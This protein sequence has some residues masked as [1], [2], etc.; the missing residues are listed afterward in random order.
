MLAEI[1]G[2]LN[3]TRG[4]HSESDLDFE[5]AYRAFTALYRSNEL[6]VIA[7]IHPQGATVFQTD[8]SQFGSGRGFFNNFLDAIDGSYCNYSAFGENGDNPT[9]DPIYPT[10]RRQCGVFKPTN[11]ISISYGL[12]EADFPANYQQRQCN[13]FMKL[14]LQGV[15]VVVA[16]GDSGAATNKNTCQGPRGDVFVPNYLSCP[17]VTLVGSTTLPEGKNPGDPEM[18]TASFSSGGGFSN[19]YTRPSY[20][21]SN[22]QS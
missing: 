14:G 9:I 1:D 2:A 18:S 10:G 5:I 13:E 11:V 15:S 6:T 20:Q 12:T 22:V 21:D 16:S 19:I 8:E 3:Y 17:Y 4:L 7:I